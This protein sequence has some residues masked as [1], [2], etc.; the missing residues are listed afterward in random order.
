MRQ[1]GL[2]PRGRAAL[3]LS[4]SAWRLCYAKVVQ[5][6]AS[7]CEED[8]YQESSKVRDTWLPVACADWPVWGA[9]AER[10]GVLCHSG[11]AVPGVP[12]GIS[13]AATDK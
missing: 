1:R 8:S 9:W 3:G 7:A 10:P 6:T 4:R 13:V 12:Q 2:H 11:S 5:L